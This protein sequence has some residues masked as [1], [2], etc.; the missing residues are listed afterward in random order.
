[1][2]GLH[3]LAVPIFVA[4]ASMASTARGTTVVPQSLIA[5]TEQAARIAHGRVVAANVVRGSDGDLYT[6]Y[7]LEILDA[8]KGSRE[9]LALRQL[10]GQLGDEVVMAAGVP[11]FHD[12]EEVLVF[13]VPDER[14]G[15]D[16]PERLAG[17]PPGP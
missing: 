12:G 6:I 5:S 4:L 11:H 8:L 15:P 7:D 1:M 13:H 10:G 2:K 14:W 9:R 3:R 17:L 16:C